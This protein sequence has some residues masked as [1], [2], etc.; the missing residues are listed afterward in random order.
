M[1]MTVRRATVD[2]SWA[3]MEA[4]VGGWLGLML[5]VSVAD[6]VFMLEYAIHWV[7]GRRAVGGQQR[8]ATDPWFTRFL[9]NIF[10]K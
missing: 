8:V 4:D 7:K 10:D 3:S 2:Y 6:L 9:R 5:G 1:K